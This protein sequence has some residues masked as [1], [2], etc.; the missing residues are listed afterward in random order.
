MKQWIINIWSKITHRDEIVKL[1]HEVS[2]IHNV[3]AKHE[4]LLKTHTCAAVDVHF[5]SPTQIIIVST[6]NDGYVKVIETNIDSM[7]DLNQIFS[8]LSAR[9]AIGRFVVDTSGPKGGPPV[10]YHGSLNKEWFF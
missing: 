6:L 4:S 2:G 10:S 8:E 3:C 1:Q 5:K 7:V 9:Y